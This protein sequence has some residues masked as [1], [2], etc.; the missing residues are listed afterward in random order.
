MFIAREQEIM[1]QP[2]LRVGPSRRLPT[3]PPRPPRRACQGRPPPLASVARAPPTRE[4]AVWRP[5]IRRRP[6]WTPSHNYGSRAGFDG[7]KH[8]QSHTRSWPRLS[9]CYGRGR[10]SYRQT[11]SWSRVASCSRVTGEGRRKYIGYSGGFIS[12]DLPSSSR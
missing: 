8:G 7:S 1:D 10:I 6:W 11:R 12:A 4:P 9:R 3:M 5:T 2:R